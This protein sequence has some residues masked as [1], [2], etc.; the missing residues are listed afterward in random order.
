MADR[1][2]SGKKPH[3]VIFATNRDGS[4][5]YVL[6]SDMMSD[7]RATRFCVEERLT[8]LRWHDARKEGIP[9]TAKLRSSDAEAEKRCAELEKTGKI[10][11]IK[12]GTKK[13]CGPLNVLLEER[14]KLAIRPMMQGFIVAKAPDGT[15]GRTGT[16]L[17]VLG[18]VRAE[19]TG[20]EKWVGTAGG[21]V[22]SSLP[23]G[24]SM[25][26]EVL[27]LPRYTEYGL[28]LLPQQ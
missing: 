19:I 12:E 28:T 15:Y 11:I 3:A 20:G 16:L 25:I 9:P 13:A 8:D 14:G 27:V 6:A 10:K 4:V 22:Y 5:G 21:M 2:T 7:E 18:D 23:D 26:G 1:V 17:T 24:A